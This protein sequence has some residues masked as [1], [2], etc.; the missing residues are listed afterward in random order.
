MKKKSLYFVIWIVSG[1]LVFLTVTGLAPARHTNSIGKVLPPDAA[2]PANQE[3]RYLANEPTSLDITVAVYTA[4]GS[5]FLFEPLTVMDE[6][7]SLLPGAAESWEASED[8]RTWTFHMR[9]RALW[10]DGRPQTAGDFEY[11]LKRSLN[12]MSGNVY[13][14][15]YYVLKNAEAYNQGKLKNPNLVGIRAVDEYTLIIETENPCPY[16]PLIMSYKTSVPVPKWQVDKYGDRWS[17][18]E[19]CVSNSSYKLV[20]WRSGDRLLFE[21]DSNYNGRHKGYLERIVR[22]ISNVETGISTGIS[23]YENDE[24]H[25]IGV[26][27]TE[28]PRVKMD[29]QLKNE[30]Y[31]NPIFQ[32]WYL[33]FQTLKPPFNDVRVRKAIA[34]AID[35]EAICRVLLQ[36]TGAPAYTM[37]PPGFPGYV[38]DKYKTLQEYNPS[39]AKH[40]LSE[41]GYPG[42]RGFPVVE[43]W[44]RGAG[45]DMVAEAIQAMLKENLGINMKILGQDRKVYVDNMYRYNIPMSLITFV[46]DFVDPHNML[47]MVWHSRP[48][49]T[50]RHDWTS[51]T[52][53]RL[54][55]DAASEMDTEKRTQMYDE[56][57]RILASDVGG[58]FIHHPLPMTLR[59]PWLKGID[60]NNAGYYTFRQPITMTKLYIG[61]R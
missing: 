6:N 38:G 47:G 55:D 1:A 3:Y 20:D 22:I 21:L 27:P 8:G 23:P 50:G 5:E 19:N 43:C 33:F 36:G 9:K 7:N 14:F 16:L 54:V 15:P 42:G 60:K 57:E 32:T 48:K 24:V 51:K 25:Q 45:R 10:S 59:K 61:D 13:P 44:L 39:R 58:V 56:A 26:S 12:P 52:F 53:D 40:L 37:L 4:D 29:P 18:D 31:I 11:A 17:N 46:Y 49:G 28:L 41:A 34:H 35:R 2:P 30:L